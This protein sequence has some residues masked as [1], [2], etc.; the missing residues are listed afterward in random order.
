MT[1]QAGR[2]FARGGVFVIEFLGGSFPEDMGYKGILN[3]QLLVP[4]KS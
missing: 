2:H 1:R 3:H 4:P